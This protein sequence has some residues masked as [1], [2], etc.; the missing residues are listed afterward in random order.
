MAQARHLLRPSANAYFRLSSADVA[1]V[2]IPAAYRT[3]AILRKNDI[4]AITK[5]FIAAN[6]GMSPAGLRV[7]TRNGTVTEIDICM[8]KGA[9]SGLADRARN[10]QRWD[11]PCLWL[12]P[13][14]HRPRQSMG[15]EPKAI[16]SQ[17]LSRA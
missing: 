11:L 6:P 9:R 12:E 2:T 3:N 8:T 15:S 1:A 4:P 17:A 16:F 14:S 7:N 10:I 13:E 5:A